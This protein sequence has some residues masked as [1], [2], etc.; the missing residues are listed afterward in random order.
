MAVRTHQI[1]VPYPRRAARIL[2]L[3]FGGL[4]L[5]AGGQQHRGQAD[6][7]RARPGADRDHPGQPDRLCLLRRGGRPGARWPACLLPTRD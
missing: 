6:P 5:V 7:G 4:L 2:A 1:P 3:V